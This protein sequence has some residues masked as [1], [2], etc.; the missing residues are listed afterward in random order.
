MKAIESLVRK[1]TDQAIKGD[2]RLTVQLTLDWPKI[3]GPHLSTITHPEKII[4]AQRVHENGRL[5]L[6]I[7]HSVYAFELSMQQDIL[8]KRINGFFGKN[9]VA[10][11]LFKHGGNVFNVLKE[12]PHSSTVSST[13]IPVA[14][15]RT[16]REV[17]EA[18]NHVK[19][20][21]LR[22]ALLSIAKHLC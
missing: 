5:H 22:E 3:V 4:F 7:I 11:I 21:D 2:A 10:K 12:L 15:P 20:P 13:V 1:I 6:H 8:I 16:H 14:T 19:D 17:F 18:A 9:L